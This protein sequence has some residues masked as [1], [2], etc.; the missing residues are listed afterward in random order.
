MCLQIIKHLCMLIFVYLGNCKIIG[1]CKY[2][3]RMNF[4]QW[5]LLIKGYLHFKFLLIFPNL[6]QVYFEMT[7][8]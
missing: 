4:W 6:G 5:N 7:Y 8:I 3:Y 1:K 2:T